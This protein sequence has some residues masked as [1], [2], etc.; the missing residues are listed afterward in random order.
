MVPTLLACF[1]VLAAPAS[2]V[3]VTA[4]QTSGPTFPFPYNWSKFPTAWFAANATNWEDDEQ[5]E[6]IGKYSMAILGWQHLDTPLDWTAV[7]YTQLTQAAII[8]NKHPELPVF[9]YCGYGFA[10]GLNAGTWPVMESVSKDPVGSPFRDFFLQSEH[11]PVFTHTN[12][13]Q[14]H[15]STGATGNHCLGYFWNMANSSARDYFVEKLVTP[16]ATAPMIDGIFYDAFN[17]GYD[18]PEVTPWG[19]QTIN[20]P[21]CTKANASWTGCEALVDGSIEVAVRTTKLLNEHGKVPMYANPGTF[22]HPLVGQHIWLNESNLVDA[23]D[24]MAWMTCESLYPLCVNVTSTRSGERG[25]KG[26]SSFIVHQMCLQY[27]WVRL[28]IL[29]AWA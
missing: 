1:V 15:T 20:V 22:K 28:E 23:L 26:Q 5:I 29:N 25:L 10:F 13:Q 12:C 24:G 7:V 4:A 8:K 14:G 19:L 11:G 27:A 18:I 2:A 3:P 16:L 6:L 17:Y 9:V 21:G